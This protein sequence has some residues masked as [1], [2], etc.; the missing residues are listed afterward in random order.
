M[1]I[2]TLMRKSSSDKMEDGRFV[3]NNQDPVPQVDPLSSD[4]LNDCRHTRC[5]HTSVIFSGS[6]FARVSV[7]LAVRI[8]TVNP[9][10]ICSELRL[11]AADMDTVVLK[12]PTVGSPTFDC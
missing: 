2:V 7:E 3:I 12:F 11:E 5:R 9:R 1:N 10:L 4:D 6:L 8:G